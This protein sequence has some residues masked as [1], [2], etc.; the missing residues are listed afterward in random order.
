MGPRLARDS[1]KKMQEAATG[2]SRA[3]LVKTDSS[4]ASLRPQGVT[5]G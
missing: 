2:A 3:A 4:G 5:D 1:A